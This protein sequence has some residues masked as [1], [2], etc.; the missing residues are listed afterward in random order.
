M[1]ARVRKAIWGHGY[2]TRDHDPQKLLDYSRIIGGEL[3]SVEMEN[4][5]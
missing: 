4:P 5:E 1:M 2:S 3:P